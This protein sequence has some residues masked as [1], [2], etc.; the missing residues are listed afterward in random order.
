MS[1]ETLRRSVEAEGKAVLATAGALA[2]GRTAADCRTRDA[3]DP[4]GPGPTPPS[5]VTAAEK[6]AWRKA[7]RQRRRRRGRAARP[8]PPARSGAEHG[9]KEFK[10]V[11]CYDQDQSRRHVTATRGDHRAAGRMVRCDAG[12]IGLTSAP[13]AGPLRRGQ[14]P[15]PA[16]GPGL[17]QRGGD[18]LPP[19]GAVPVPDAGGHPRPQGRRPAR[20]ERDAGVRR[21]EAE[22]LGRVHGHR[23]HEADGTGVDLRLVPQLPRAV[24]AAR[25]SGAGLCLLGGA[26]AGRARGCG[27][28]TGGGSGSSRAIG[29]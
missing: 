22:R 21:D 29:R 2:I 3:A 14:A 16:A 9:Y 25:A 13:E 20:P 15:A 18:P 23:R 7:M 5:L 6:A 12:R 8:L 19:G 4:T 11:A 27:R 10:I 28:R 24:E 26:R 17:L 1:G